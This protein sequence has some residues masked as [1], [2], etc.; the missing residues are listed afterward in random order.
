MDQRIGIA[1]A[2]MLLVLAS[3]VGCGGGMEKFRAQVLPIV[4]KVSDR[5]KGAAALT[6]GEPAKTI[7][8]ASAY[9]TDLAGLGA[10]L[11][12]L[13]VDGEKQ[14]ALVAAGQAYL[15]ATQRFVTAQQAFARTVVRLDAARAKVRE[16]LDAKA[17]TSKFSLDFWKESHDRLTLDLDKVRKEAEQAREKLVAA[18]TAMEQAATATGALLGREAIVAPDVLA[19]HRKALDAVPLA[20]GA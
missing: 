5:L 4:A 8:Q 1:T 9:L 6:A 12:G 20:K 13:Y 16:S 14:Q 11:K 2:S 17:R 3:A 7:E 15:A 19:A 18:T 10:D